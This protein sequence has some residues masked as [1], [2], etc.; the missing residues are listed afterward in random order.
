MGW[1]EWLESNP[2]ALQRTRIP[3]PAWQYLRAGRVDHPAPRQQLNTLEQPGFAIGVLGEDRPSLC[4]VSSLQDQHAS[5]HA[6]AIGREE[7]PTNLDPLAL[8]LQ[9]FQIGR[10]VG[11]PGLQPV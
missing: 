11:K 7:W 3:N 4:L 1:R 5:D 6:L 9:K 8:C 2:H 10:T